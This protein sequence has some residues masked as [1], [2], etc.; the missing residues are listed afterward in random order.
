MTSEEFAALV[1]MRALRDIS[2]RL[3]NQ[4]ALLQ[5]ID[6][7]TKQRGWWSDFG[8]N[9]AGNAVWDSLLYIMRK[10]LK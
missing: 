2:R 1:R 8:S 5:D 4:S 10:L 9:V 7:R 3:D 6:K